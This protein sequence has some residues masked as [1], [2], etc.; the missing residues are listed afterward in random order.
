MDH[1]E[2]KLTN[3]QYNADNGACFIT[4]ENTEASVPSTSN[5]TVLKDQLLDI[6]DGPQIVKKK[7]LQERQ[8][9]G[10]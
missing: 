9:D 3:E 7:V 1:N 10:K 8:P 5:I 4:V 2:R 6:Y